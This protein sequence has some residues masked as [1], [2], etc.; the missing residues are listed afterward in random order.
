MLNSDE[1]GPN[2]KKIIKWILEYPKDPVFL[3]KVQNV[4]KIV[5]KFSIS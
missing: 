2:Q 5:P 3:K 1:F 4:V